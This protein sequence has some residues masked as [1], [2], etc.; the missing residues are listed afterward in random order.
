MGRQRK[1]Y[2]IEVFCGLARSELPCIIVRLQCDHR[3]RASQRFPWQLPYDRFHH[4][5]H[6]RRDRLQASVDQDVGLAILVAR[7]NE[8]RREAQIIA[9][10]PCPRLCA[11]KRVGTSFDDAIGDALSLYYAPKARRRL[12]DRERHRCAASTLLFE[13]EG[14]RKT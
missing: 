14:G 3:A 9:Q 4:H 11:E 5:L 13:I 7:A 6:A 10:L 8:L 2:M 12:K 1:D